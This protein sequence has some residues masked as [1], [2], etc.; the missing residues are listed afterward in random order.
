MLYFKEAI[1]GK[2]SLLDTAFQRLI[3]LTGTSGSDILFSSSFF[4]FSS[5]S[6][7]SSSS[8]FIAS[9]CSNSG[10]KDLINKGDDGCGGGGVGRLTKR[11][12]AFFKALLEAYNGGGGEVVDSVHLQL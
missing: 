4:S 5:P 9:G 7:S 11:R 8:S 6:S 2:T 3:K 1:L 12:W 10:G